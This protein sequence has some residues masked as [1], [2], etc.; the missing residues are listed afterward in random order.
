[1]CRLPRLAGYK[2]PVA[3]R[4]MYP[5]KAIGDH[6]PERAGQGTRR[7]SGRPALPSGPN[8]VKVARLYF[9]PDEAS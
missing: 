4:K 7:R 2:R 1:M 6:V 3:W 9:F 5:F 8:A